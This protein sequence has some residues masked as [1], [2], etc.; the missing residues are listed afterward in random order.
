MLS[1]VVEIPNFLGYNMVL[2][3][4][5]FTLATGLTNSLTLKME[6][7]CFSEILVNAHQTAQYYIPENG[8]FHSHQYKN[9]KV[10][11]P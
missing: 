4:A 2:L 3:A 8:S 1:L 7:V 9:L 10:S 5:C 11:R 6:S